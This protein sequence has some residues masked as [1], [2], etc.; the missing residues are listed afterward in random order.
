M[1]VISKPYNWSAGSVIVGSEHNADHDTIYSEFNGNIDDNNI[2]SGANIQGTKLLD[3]SIPTSKLANLSVI[4]GK[5]DFGA[6]RVIKP[7]IVGL[8]FAR[9]SKA[10][11]IGGGV[12][13]PT[14]ITFSTESDD[15][16]PQ[17]GATPRIQISVIA[18]G[19]NSLAALITTKSNLSFIFKVF[20]AGAESGTVEWYAIGV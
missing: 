20:G 18:P 15:G 14:T 9:G 17:F 5:I 2:K 7:G 12:A 1:G 3:N 13:G 6:T 8:K 16:D 4:D 10:F 11:T 19:A